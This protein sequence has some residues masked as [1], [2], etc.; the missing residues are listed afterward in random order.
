MPPD[1][2]A[3]LPGG[4]NQALDVWLRDNHAGCLGITVMDFP[5]TATILKIM[6][7]NL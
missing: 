6:M 5:G 7:S 4:P 1:F 3:S 2:L